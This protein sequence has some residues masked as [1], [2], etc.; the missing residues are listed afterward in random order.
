M[1]RSQSLL[2]ALVAGL[3][4]GCAPAGDG[5]TRAAECVLTAGYRPGAAIGLA[6]LARVDA[7]PVVVGSWDGWQRPAP[8]S[9]RWVEATDRDGLKWQLFSAALPP[10][11][12]QYAILVDDILVTDEANPRTGFAPDP[13]AP[14]G[15]P[16][17][18]EVSEIEIPDCALP[19][20][21]VVDAHEEAGALSVTARFIR[22]AGGARL[23]PHALAAEL[24]R[25]ADQLAAPTVELDGTLDGA[26]RLRVRIPDLSPG[27]YTVR[28]SAAA[29]D[30]RAAAPVDASAFI[31]ASPGRGLGDGLLYQIVIDRFRGGAGP[32]APPSTPGER[33]GGTLDGVRAAIEAGYFD[34]LGVTTLWLSPVYT[35]PPGHF[36][37]RDGHLYEAYHGYWPAE[38]RSVEPQLGGE[39]QLDALMA[40]AHARGLRVI[41]DAVPNHVYEGHPYYQQHSLLDEAVAT[42]PS[43]RLADWFNDGPSACVCGSPGCDWG[44]HMETCWFDRYLPDVDWRNPDVLTV[45]V[46][47]LK[48]WAQ[49]FDLDGLRIDAVPLMPRAATRRIVHGLHTD[50]HRQGLDLLMIGETYTGPGDGGRAAIRAYLGEALDGLDS[51]F[52]FPLMWSARKV[53]A[54]GE[55]SFAELEG[56]LASGTQT[57]ANSGAV[58][59]RIIGNHDTT[60]FL[61]EAQGDAGGDPWTAAPAQPDSEEPYRRQVLALAYMLT[62]PGLP[63]IYYGDELGLAGATDPDSRRVLPDVLAPDQLPALERQTL[64]AVARLGRLRACSPALRSDSRKPILADDDHLVA[65]SQPPSGEPALVVIS[66]ATGPTQVPAAGIPHRQWR[67]AMS[68]Q[69]LTIDDTTLWVAVPPLSVA[70]YLPEGS[71]CLE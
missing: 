46:D 59:A 45:G 47:D 71:A 50:V 43:P 24:R 30:G 10:G 23:D 52:D 48:W 55:G 13:R 54:R 14:G 33:A 49:R 18:T 21:E 19:A 17:G 15:D 44:A 58:I 26:P 7:Q 32:L 29:L 36:T 20:L 22:G 56:E 9:Q 27:K 57:W 64:D 38:P 8:G 4:S 6:K 66:R 67:D 51:E 68:G 65:L 34:R 5:P 60:R 2:V 70:V 12:Y 31:E 35:N 11:T 1:Q 28:L 69:L 61:S 40:S 63:V 62:V 37:G 3:A 25:G 41:L 16:L 42:A 53:I 39:A